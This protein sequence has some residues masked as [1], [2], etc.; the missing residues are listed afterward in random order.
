MLINRLEDRKRMVDYSKGERQRV[1][2]V[3]SSEVESFLAGYQNDPDLSR[4][5]LEGIGYVERI[6]RKDY[7]TSVTTVLGELRRIAMETDFVHEKRLPA[8]SID[9]IKK[10]ADRIDPK[11]LPFFMDYALLYGVA[12]ARGFLEQRDPNQPKE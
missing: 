3:S 2:R 4:G 8:K 7:P 11:C 5:I 9:R 10:I 1:G 12:N 6:L